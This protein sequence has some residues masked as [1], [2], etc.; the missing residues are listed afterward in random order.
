MIEKSTLCVM[1]RLSLTIHLHHSDKQIKVVKY[2]QTHIKLQN[3]I[4][5]YEVQALS[6]AAPANKHNSG[7][8]FTTTVYKYATEVI[9]T[10]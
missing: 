10:C 8:T 6:L 1:A 2:D 3:S 9:K 4:G 7:T 5:I